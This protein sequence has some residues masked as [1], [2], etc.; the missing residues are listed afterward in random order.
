MSALSLFVAVTPDCTSRLINRNQ[1]WMKLILAALRKPRTSKS[2][3]GPIWCKRLFYFG[4][5]YCRSRSFLS[6]GSFLPQHRGDLQSAAGKQQCVCERE[7]Q[8]VADRRPHTNSGFVTVRQGAIKLLFSIP[9]SSSSSFYSVL[10]TPGWLGVRKREL[11]AVFIDHVTGQTGNTKRNSLNWNKSMSGK[12]WF[13]AVFVLIVPSHVAYFTKQQRKHFF[14]ITPVVIN[15][16]MSLT[17][18]KDEEG[19]NRKW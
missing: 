13:L 3:A 10:T 8:R 5:C 16:W 1:N 15:N 12:I 6:A 17:D 14:H 7:R 19:D 4:S 2:K 11:R 18:G 9:P